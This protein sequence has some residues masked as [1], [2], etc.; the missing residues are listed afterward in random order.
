MA[1]KKR[2]RPDRKDPKTNKSL[3]I[4]LTLNKLPKAKAADVAAA[5]KQDYGHAVK[6]N[7]VYMVK[8]KSNLA[9][10]SRGDGVKRSTPS[11]NTARLWV[12]A[13]KLSR[14]LLKATG[15]LENATALLKAVN[16]E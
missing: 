1:A 6:P 7:M 8:A 14:Q 16:G 13:I 10:K 4:R 11:L 12:D 2:K 5:V 3:A 15:G 9:K